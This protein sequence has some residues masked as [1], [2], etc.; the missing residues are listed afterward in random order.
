MRRQHTGASWIG[1][2]M[3]MVNA[4]T[5][6]GLAKV[7]RCGECGGQGSH[8]DGLQCLGCQGFGVQLWHACPACGDLGYDKLS[9]G[10]YA[11]RIRCG[12][13]WTEDDP[14]WQAQYLPTDAFT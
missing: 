12:H 4:L 10:T 3:T 5:P 6:P 2:V 8:S 11:C 7:M 9:D 1:E 13:T 14:A